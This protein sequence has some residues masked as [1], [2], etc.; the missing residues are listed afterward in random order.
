[1]SLADSPV[2]PA[3]SLS[4]RESPRLLARATFIALARP[5]QASPCE[6]A[7]TTSALRAESANTS[8]NRR[9]R[10]VLCA[11][12]IAQHTDRGEIGRERAGERPSRR[13]RTDIGNTPLSLTLRSPAVSTTEVC[14][15]CV[16]RERPLDT[17]PNY[18]L[19]RRLALPLPH[20]LSLSVSPSINTLINYPR[21]LG[22]LRNAHVRACDNI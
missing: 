18:P 17:W 6:H 3:S 9:R 12:G 2:Y 13:D 10:C 1:M 20:P 7:T 21:A 4:S 5:G 15:A 8:A 22:T 19:A 16:N 14:R 11:N